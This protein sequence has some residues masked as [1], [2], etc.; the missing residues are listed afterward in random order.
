MGLFSQLIKVGQERALVYFAVLC[1]CLKRRKTTQI[2]VIASTEARNGDLPSTS[3][4]GHGCA[5][6]NGE[7]EVCLNHSHQVYKQR[8]QNSWLPAIGLLVRLFIKQF[9]EL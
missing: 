5:S 4:L 9:C 3:Q 2:S 6:R 7:Q 8:K 1:C